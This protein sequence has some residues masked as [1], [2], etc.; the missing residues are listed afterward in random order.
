M[1]DAQ[2]ERRLIAGGS[3]VKLNRMGRGEDGGMEKK[4]E[5]LMD[6]DNSV[7]MARG[8]GG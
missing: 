2:I 5:K 8:E 6:P 1:T 7:V 4:E 3:G